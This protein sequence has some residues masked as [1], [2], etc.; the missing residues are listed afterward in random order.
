MT[1]LHFI[2]L[3]LLATAYICHHAKGLWKTAI[4]TPFK[5]AVSIHQFVMWKAVDDSLG[6]SIVTSN[7]LAVVSLQVYIRDQR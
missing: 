1:K 6:G 2:C 5:A 3:L 4:D 7:L